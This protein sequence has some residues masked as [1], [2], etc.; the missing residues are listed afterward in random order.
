M[1][2]RA[3]LAAALMAGLL[4]LYQMLFLS[5]PASPPPPA[6]TPAEAPKAAPQP[7]V[8]QP[9]PPQKELQPAA[10]Q[11]TAT[12]ETPLYRAVISSGGGRLQEWVIHYRGEKPMV[13][14]DA[15]G[16]EGLMV[17]RAGAQAQA[18]PFHLSA[19]HLRLGKDTPSGELR[20]TGEDGFGLRVTRTLRFRADS[21]VVEEEITVENRHSVAQSA[22]LAL[23]WTAPVEWPNPE[24]L[25]TGPRPIHVVRLENGAFWARR[26]YL[27]DASD[28]VGASRWIGLESGIYPGVY[29]AAQN[30][31]YLTALIP[32]SPSFKVTEAKVGETKGD[33]ASPERRVRIGLRAT[34]PLLQPGQAWQGHLLTY[35]GPMEYDRL[36]AVGVALE[37]AIYFGGF[38][39][40][41][42][43]AQGSAV[44]TLPMA[45]VAVP[46]LWFMHRFYDLMGN[47][48]IAIILLTIITKVLFFPLTLKSMR[49]MKAMQAI[50]PQVNALR[51]KHK[52]DSQRLQR[53]TMELYRKHRVNPLGGCLPMIVQIPI[54]YALYVALSVSAEIQNA[55]FI[56]F[57]RVFGA[58][59][60][61]CDLAAQDPTYVLPILMGASM[62]IQ[63]KMTPTMGDPRQAKMMLIMPF[64]F[65]FMFL[66]LPSGLVLYWTVSNVLQILQQHYMDRQAKGLKSTGKATKGA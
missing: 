43:W 48:G 57:G 29:A 26:T 45:W 61:I 17:Q 37:K 50:Q 6:Q 64:V 5:P 38:P 23:A 58:E 12:V 18:I 41:E 32:M 49:S 56:C 25:V 19:E 47:Y 66:S 14:F 55:P 35:I 62:F 39:F 24:E 34:L 27:A 54:F 13:V 33:Q 52:N 65:T 42:S 51:S 44:P 21:Y 59:L 10:P 11:R 46:I 22:E 1:E 53:E 4:I 3:I 15:L 60:W 2:K 28:F 16:P 7:V 40:P 8:L 36:R 30:G 31:V 9:L 20:L 63:Q